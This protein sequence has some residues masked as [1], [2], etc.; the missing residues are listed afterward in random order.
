M[1]RQPHTDEIFHFAV[2][3]VVLSANVAGS[4]LAFGGGPDDRYRP[5]PMTTVQAVARAFAA[6]PG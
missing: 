5:A 6:H 2:L 3:A 1:I 4:M